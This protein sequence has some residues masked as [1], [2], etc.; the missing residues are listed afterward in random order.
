MEILLTRLALAKAVVAAV[1]YPSRADT[2]SIGRKTLPLS[3]LTKK[4]WN[5]FSSFTPIRGNAMP[6]TLPDSLHVI[7]SQS[8]ADVPDVFHPLR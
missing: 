5:K 6:T 3:S 1:V 8:H 2:Y 7:P 4:D